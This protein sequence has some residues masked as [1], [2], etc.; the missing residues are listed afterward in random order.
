MNA[1]YP[2]PVNPAIQQAK[3]ESD[4]KTL[5]M[6][7]YVWSALLGCSGVGI[8]GYF[9]AVAAVVEQAPTR[10]GTDPQAQAVA[11]GAMAIVGFI[12]AAIMVLLFVVHIMAAS[13]LKTRKRPTLIIIASA[14]ACTHMPLGTALGV[15]TIMVMQ[16]PT[17]KALFGRTG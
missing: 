11:M 9:I 1:A 10:A 15:W 5:S 13:G 12:I 8:I 3:D 6:L 14:L 4:L 16:R 2:Y 17:V 7:H